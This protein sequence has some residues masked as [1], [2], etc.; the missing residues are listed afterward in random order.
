MS[1]EKYNE[2]IQDLLYEDIPGD[3][4]KKEE[5]NLFEKWDNIYRHI[6]KEKL[7]KG[8]VKVSPADTR[9]LHKSNIINQV[10]KDH[11]TARS[12]STTS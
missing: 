6:R 1:K 2:W 4:V 5:L 12:I 10:Q 9:D 7:S 8:I 11:K 3:I